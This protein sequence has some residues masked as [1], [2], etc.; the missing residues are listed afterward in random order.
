MPGMGGC[1]EWQTIMFVFNIAEII[2]FLFDLYIEYRMVSKNCPF[3]FP[4]IF[5][6]GKRK[7][8]INMQKSLSKK[9][10]DKI[11]DLYI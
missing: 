2:K 11:V 9:D 6:S 4:L 1:P 5:E 7:V 3:V 10:F 8:K